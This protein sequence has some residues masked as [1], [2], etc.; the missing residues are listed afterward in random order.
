MHS[1]GQLTFNPSLYNSWSAHDSTS[2]REKCMTFLHLTMSH[3]DVF[4]PVMELRFQQFRMHSEARRSNLPVSTD[5]CTSAH[6][7]PRCFPDVTSKEKRHILAYCP[8]NKHGTYL[9]TPLL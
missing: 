9:A 1:I 3:F 2:N 5:Y 4:S 7:R 8:R 6:F